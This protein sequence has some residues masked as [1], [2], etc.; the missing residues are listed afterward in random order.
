MFV[1]PEG[2][3]TQKS[4]SHGHRSLA[5]SENFGLGQQTGSVGPRVVSRF[6]AEKKEGH[7]PFAVPPIW[8]LEHRT[9]CDAVVAETR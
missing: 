1:T 5:L 3:D 9:D 4:L 8:I 7:L 6:V 2:A